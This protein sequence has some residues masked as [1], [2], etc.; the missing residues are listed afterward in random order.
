MQHVG[1]FVCMGVIALGPAEQVSRCGGG[2]R[3][4][5]AL[6]C[7]F[8][9]SDCLLLTAVMSVDTSMSRVV[10]AHKRCFQN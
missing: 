7:S 9:W 2:I 6:S 5:V 1:P 8:D 3:G 10:N 4:S